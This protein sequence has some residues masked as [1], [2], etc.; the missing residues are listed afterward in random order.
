MFCNSFIPRSAGRAQRWSIMVMCHTSLIQYKY[1]MCVCVDY[2]TGENLC[3]ILWFTYWI[4]WLCWD[5]LGGKKIC[6]NLQFS[7]Q[8]RIS[9]YWQSK[10]SWYFLPISVLRWAEP[11][12]LSSTTSHVCSS[13]R[14]TRNIFFVTPRPLPVDE[15]TSLIRLRKRTRCKTRSL[16]PFVQIRRQ[17]HVEL[18][19]IGYFSVSGGVHHH[20]AQ[21]AE[22]GGCLS[23]VHLV[24]RSA[25]VPLLSARRHLP[26]Q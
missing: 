14:A 19:H 12:I 4:L 15:D 22:G 26:L 2:N 20:D 13:S 21:Q 1:A 18:S 11:N 7:W 25:A 23:A 3:M 16:T 10:P 8:G 5:L 24:D 9:K 17:N 6:E